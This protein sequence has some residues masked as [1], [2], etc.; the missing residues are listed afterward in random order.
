LNILL[1][2]SK[3]ILLDLIKHDSVFKS[4]LIL[5]NPKQAAKARLHL[6]V[7][8]IGQYN[9]LCSLLK[10][11]GYGGKV[12]LHKLEVDQDALTSERST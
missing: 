10:A 6:R 9:Y 7:A 3:D 11:K 1:K 4:L 5:T 2:Q 8:S 12:S